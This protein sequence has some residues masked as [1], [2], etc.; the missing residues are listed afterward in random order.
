[1]VVRHAEVDAVDETFLID[2]YRCRPA[3]HTVTLAD[4]SAPVRNQLECES[5][6]S[7]NLGDAQRVF[8]VVDRQDDGSLLTSLI[9]QTLQTTQ[10]PDARR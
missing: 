8:T 2:G 4:S 5:V 9:V 7:A 6:L 1:L 3:V 10:L